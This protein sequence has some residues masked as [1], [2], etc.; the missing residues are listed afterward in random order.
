MQI[1]HLATAVILL[2]TS[3]V[4]TAQALRPSDFALLDQYGQFHQ[5]SRYGEDDAVVVVVFG[6][7]DTASQLAAQS[8]N[9]LKTSYSDASVQFFLLSADVAVDRSALEIELDALGIDMPV[10]LDSAQVVAKAL[11]LTHLAQAAIIDPSSYEVLYRGPMQS[12]A[13]SDVTP[14]LDNSLRALL[15]GARGDLEELP[16]DSATALTFV[17]QDEIAANGLSYQEDIAPIFLRRCARC[18]VDDGLAP[19]A[20]SSHRMLQGWSPMMR[21]VLLTKRMP[22]GQIDTSVGEWSHINEI[23]D[24]E[25]AKLID[26]ID[27]GARRDGEDDPMARESLVQP[28]WV[29]GEPDLIVEVPEQKVPATG[30]VDFRFEYAELGLNEDKWI[31]AVAY[32]VGDQSVLHSLMVYALKPG[33]SKVDTAGLV[34]PSNAEFISIY[35][36]GQGDD[37]FS[38]DSGFL[39][40]KGHDLAFK[41]RYVSSGRETQDNTRIG[42]YFRDK[43]LMQ[44]RNIPVFRDD[45]VIAAGEPNH[46]VLAQA[47]PTDRDA[48]IEAVAPQM[49]GRGVSMK[50]FVSTEDAV[51]KPVINVPNYNFNWQFNY[52]LRQRLFIP[53]GSVLE[54]D[55]GYDNS[56]SNVYNP[57]PEADVRYGVTTWDE[58]LSHYVRTVSPVVD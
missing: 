53:A 32:D 11:G 57:D 51:R 42:L 1:S 47:L 17:Y 7:G 9:E 8:L 27:S 52:Q 24:K 45:L 49:H 39:L 22:P 37:E 25:L 5:L 23:D 54:V 58:I 35:V 10:L 44:V 28:D 2:L 40:E 46:R 14:Y 12:M 20:M 38:I 16:M 19:W 26:W 56:A 31:G 13:S 43:P 48:Y 30:V 36:P 50:L 33:I 55:T 15:S 3:V 34:H 41:I 21:E 29:L 18:H 4:S 6:P